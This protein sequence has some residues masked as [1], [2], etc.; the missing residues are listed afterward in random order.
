MTRPALRPDVPWQ[1]QMFEKSLKKR[2]KVTLLLD[3]LGPLEGMRCL[4]LTCG[5]NNGAMNHHFRASGG[6]WKW[7]DVEEAGIAAMA[8]F[9]HE[10]VEHAS[11]DELPFADGSFDRVVVI[12]VHEHLEDVD[13]LNREIARV[14]D[15]GGLAVVT[16][17]NGN[18]RLPV[19][20]LK[21]VIGMSPSEY[22][23]VVQGYDVPE[24]ES[25]L[26]AQGLRPVRTGAYSRFFT[27]IAELAINFAYVK[28]LSRKSQDVIPKGTIAPGSAEQ[29]RRVEKSYRMYSRVYPV[30]KGFSLLDGLIPGSGGY[31]VA[32]AARKAT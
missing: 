32:V 17:P 10:P 26:A 9:L 1:L 7:S 3:L 11:P 24:L 21:R 15:S 13:A 19:A 30:L 12:D 2:Q 14:L 22:G 5:D 25:M 20:R 16:T 4:L 27:E 28:I 18:P 6:L 29:L 23:H 31:A 8:A